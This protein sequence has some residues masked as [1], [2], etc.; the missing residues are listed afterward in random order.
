MSVVWLEGVSPPDFRAETFT[1][2]EILGWP[3]ERQEALREELAC[4]FPRV[5]LSEKDWRY[6]VRHYFFDPLPRTRHGLWVRSGSGELLGV[7]CFDIGPAVY[8]GMEKRAAYVH[9]RALLPEAQASGLGRAMARWMLGFMPDC[10][11]TTCMQPAS[12]YSWIGLVGAMTDRA[13][14]VWP[15]PDGKGG[16]TPLPPERLG[17]AFGLFMQIYSGHVKEDAARVEAVVRDLTVRFVRRGVGMTYARN[18]WIFPERDA[19][20]EALDLRESDG[21]L[22]MVRR[23]F[24][25]DRKAQT[26]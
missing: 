24:Q 23:V 8:G 25:G 19:M 21:V 11:F 17:E 16:V 9:I 22:L 20:A 7:A 6:V 12:L 15:C 18:P 4:F 26:P 10:L 14:E 1:T 13:Y 5:F 3:A 2:R